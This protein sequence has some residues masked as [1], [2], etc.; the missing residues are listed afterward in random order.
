MERAE[1][2][3]VRAEGRYR[4]MGVKHNENITIEQEL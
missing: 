4:M 3:F 1:I 2:H